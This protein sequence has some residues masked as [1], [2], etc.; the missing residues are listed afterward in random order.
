MV[1]LLLM[2]ATFLSFL[3]LIGSALL[4]PEFF[5]FL[6]G[7]ATQRFREIKNFA[8]FFFFIGA[9]GGNRTDGPR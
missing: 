3:T 6:A 8:K 1:A 7:E 9:G 2:S 4:R 5:G